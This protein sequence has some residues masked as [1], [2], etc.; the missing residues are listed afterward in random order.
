MLEE[1]LEATLSHKDIL[2]FCFQTT[3]FPWLKRFSNFMQLFMFAVRL[4]V[5]PTEMWTYL[6][7][8]NYGVYKINYFF[9]SSVLP[10][11]VSFCF[12]PLF[13]TGWLDNMIMRT[14]LV[15]LLTYCYEWCILCAFSVSKGAYCWVRDLLLLTRLFK[16]A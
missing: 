11:C 16:Y 9:L 5:H 6:T 1:F 2:N 15:L 13:S 8:G 10:N 14:R 4:F 7:V 12:A 3:G